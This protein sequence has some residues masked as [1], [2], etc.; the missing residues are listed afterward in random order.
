MSTDVPYDFVLAEDDRDAAI[1]RTITDEDGNP[2]DV[3][4]ATI[5]FLMEAPD[6]TEVIRD[7]ANTS[8]VTD[9]TDG[10]IQ[11]SWGETDT[12]TPGSYRARFIIDKTTGRQETWPNHRWLEI[13]I[14]ES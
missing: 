12:A 4:G 5:T 3:S 14:T 7:A 9:G 8:F 6:G 11:Y 1:I 10:Q 13:L 2:E